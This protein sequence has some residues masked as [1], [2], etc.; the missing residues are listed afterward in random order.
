[1]H[2]YKAQDPLTL[3]SSELIIFAPRDLETPGPLDRLLERG[4]VLIF[5]F[6]EIAASLALFADF[7]LFG[8]FRT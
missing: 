5:L 2:L 3:S 6:G 4:K 7:V 1:M 8:T